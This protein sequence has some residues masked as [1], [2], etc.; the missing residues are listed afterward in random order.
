MDLDLTYFLPLTLDWLE[1][2]GDLS[3]AREHLVSSQEN[4]FPFFLTLKYHRRIKPCENADHS[5]IND[6][7]IT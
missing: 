3:I 5:E 1:V 4:K 7:R 2:L 6:N